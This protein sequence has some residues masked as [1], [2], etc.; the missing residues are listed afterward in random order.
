M[1]ERCQCHCTIH[2]AKVEV[3]TRDADRWIADLDA[4]V[5]RQLG[6]RKR[7]VGLD[8]RAP[9]LNSGLKRHEHTVR[10][11]EMHVAE[12]GAVDKLRQSA[13]VAKGAVNEDALHVAITVNLNPLIDV[14]LSSDFVHFVVLHTRKLTRFGQALRRVALSAGHRHESQSGDANA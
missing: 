8:D 6:S 1:S 3:P 5:K 2:I 11:V 4:L 9:D 10:N 13:S 7:G 12:N 14:T